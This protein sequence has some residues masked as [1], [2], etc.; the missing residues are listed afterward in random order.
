M[1]LGHTQGVSIFCLVVLV[2]ARGAGIVGIS[3][4]GISSVTSNPPASCSGS[5]G[6]MT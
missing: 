2:L 5:R 1:M 6:A 4:S 3:F